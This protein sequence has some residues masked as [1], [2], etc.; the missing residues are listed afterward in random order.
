MPT[1]EETSWSVVLFTAGH[2]WASQLRMMTR[3][4]LITSTTTLSPEVIYQTL[5]DDRTGYD[6]TWINQC[7]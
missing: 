5:G 3:R 7:L 4:S 1:A 6:H 2:P